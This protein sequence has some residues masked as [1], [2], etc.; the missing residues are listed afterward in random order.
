MPANE[1]PFESTGD[2]AI[3]CDSQLSIDIDLPPREIQ[4][5]PS[6]FYIYSNIV[7]PWSVMGEYRKLL[8]IVAIEQDEYDENVTIDFHKPEYHNLS[9]HH[10]RKLRFQITTGEDALIEPFSEN[11]RMYISLR[12]SYN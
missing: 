5:Y 4:L 12:F 1:L 6:E 9:E 10:P 3:Y 11:D 2:V 7:E 8:K